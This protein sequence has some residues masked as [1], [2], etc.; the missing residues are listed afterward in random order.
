MTALQTFFLFMWAFV[1]LCLLVFSPGR[2]LHKKLAGLSREEVK[3]LYRQKD[4]KGS[5]MGCRALPGLLL[6]FV[7]TVV[8]EPAY[9]LWAIFAHVHPLF[10]A[11]GAMGIVILNLLDSIVQHAIR[12]PDGAVFSRINW[13]YWIR[14]AIFALPTFYLWYLF[15]VTIGLG[16]VR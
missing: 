13:L 11:Y 5:S 7:Q 10:L 6:E 4:E 14:V 2:M 15:L 1:G 3:T 9:A 8:V 16:F 12:K